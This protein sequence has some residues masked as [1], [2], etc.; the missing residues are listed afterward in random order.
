MKSTE[1][2]RCIINVDGSKTCD[3]IIQ[4]YVTEEPAREWEQ[5]SPQPV[6]YAQQ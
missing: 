5:M 2:K 4:K 6:G 3:K 1:Y